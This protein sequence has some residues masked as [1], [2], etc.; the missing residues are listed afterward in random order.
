MHIYLM[1]AKEKETIPCDQMDDLLDILNNKFV[2]LWMFRNGDKVQVIK[3]DKPDEIL[4]E[5]EVYPNPYWQP[6]VLDVNPSSLQN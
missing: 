4:H 5:C 3:L 6:I 2:L 1:E